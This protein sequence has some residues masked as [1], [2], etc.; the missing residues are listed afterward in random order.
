MMNTCR[1]LSSAPKFVSSGTL[2]SI[3]LLQKVEQPAYWTWLIYLH[4]IDLNGCCNGLW[5]HRGLENTGRRTYWTILWR[6]VPPWRSG[7]HC[8]VHPETRF[9]V[10]ASKMHAEYTA[11]E[12]IRAWIVGLISVVS[13]HKDEEVQCLSIADLQIVVSFMLYSDQ[14]LANQPRRSVKSKPRQCWKLVVRRPV[15]AH[16]CCRKPW[17]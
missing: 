10:V 11:C 14:S 4:L 9:T 13:A 3:C 16:S 17:K 12:F 15:V 8:Y 7:K 1:K 6:Y 5:S 2:I